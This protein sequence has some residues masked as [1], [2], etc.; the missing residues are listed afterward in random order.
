MHFGIAPSLRGIWPDGSIGWAIR[1]TINNSING[2][3]A[4]IVFFVISGF[5]I[6]YPRA[7]GRKLDIFE[8]YASRYIRIMP[9]MIAAASIWVMMGSELEILAISILWSLYAELAYYTAYPV[10]LQIRKIWGWSWIFGLSVASWATVILSQP[11]AVQYQ[12]HGVALTCVLG[13]PCWL[14]GCVLAERMKLGTAKTLPPSS[15]SIWAW[16]LMIWLLSVVASA[17]EFH[18]PIG[19]PITL[20]IFAVA[21]FFWLEREVLW[22]NAR[23]A[24][25][26]LE[27]FG[28]WSYSTYLMH[29]PIATA[30]VILCRLA[31]VRVSFADPLTILVV[32]FGCYLFYR[33]VEDPSHRLAKTIARLIASRR[34]TFKPL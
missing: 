28:R 15:R 32:L 5:C 3:A 10:V 4:V 27:W 16:R 33:L 30:T 26:I 31:G 13:L 6:H 20:N 12:D 34:Y 18:S 24:V 25:P 14:L 2:Q 21:V 23:G 29:L 17:L 7:E 22:A 9:P 8:F 1:S 11:A 19:A